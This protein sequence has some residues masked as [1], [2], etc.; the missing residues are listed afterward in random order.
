MFFSMQDLC[1]GLVKHR[2]KGERENNI[3]L[4]R[5]KEEILGRLG[6]YMTKF[7]KKDSGKFMDKVSSHRD[8][9]YFLDQRSELDRHN[10]YGDMIFEEKIAKNTDHELMVKL[11]NTLS[12]HNINKVMDKNNQD[13]EKIKQML[14]VSIVRN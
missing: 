5:E 6:G 9:R 10:K 13:S 1:K 2:N 4:Q 14:R 12:N 7:N 3:K 11:A 8:M